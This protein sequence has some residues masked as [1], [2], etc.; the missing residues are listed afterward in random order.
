MTKSK[1]IEQVGI[2]ITSLGLAQYCNSLL[3]RQLKNRSIGAITFNEKGTMSYSIH[4]QGEK[5]K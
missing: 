1:L 3:I 4:K 2:I 5:N